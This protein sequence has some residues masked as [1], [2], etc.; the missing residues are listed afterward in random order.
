MADFFTLDSFLGNGTNSGWGKMAIDLGGNFLNY[1]QAQDAR[2]DKIDMFNRQFAKESQQLDFQN[3]E[4]L[5]KKKKEKEAWDK[6]Q[7]SYT[8]V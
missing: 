4:Y 5:D 7:S 3:S 8:M 1:K 2:R 6:Y